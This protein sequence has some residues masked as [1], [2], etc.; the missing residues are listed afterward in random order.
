M[1]SARWEYRVLLSHGINDKKIIGLEQ[2]LNRLG[3]DG[4]EL[5]SVIVRPEVPANEEA[6]GQAGNPRAPRTA[7]FLRRKRDD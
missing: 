2:D 3:A 5:V 4:C 1:P 6:E 7:M